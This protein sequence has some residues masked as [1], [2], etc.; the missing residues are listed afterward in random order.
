MA[1]KYLIETFGCQMNVHDSSGWPGR[2]GRLRAD[3]RRG[4]RRRGGDQH[5]QRRERAEKS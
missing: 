3:R 2:A 4:G 1:R 5:L